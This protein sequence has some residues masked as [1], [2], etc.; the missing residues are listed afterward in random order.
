MEFPQRNNESDKGSLSIRRPKTYE[1]Q[2][3]TV[4]DTRKETELSKKQV[5]EAVEIMEKAK[6]DVQMRMYDFV[7]MQRDHPALINARVRSEELK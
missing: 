6:F 3:D 7:K 2:M 1:E 4:R 5:L